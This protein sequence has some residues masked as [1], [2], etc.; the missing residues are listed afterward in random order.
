SI[1]IF[2]C[3]VLMELVRM[4]SY[5]NAQLTRLVVQQQQKKKERL[6]LIKTALSLCTPNWTRCYEKDFGMSRPMR[7]LNGPFVSWGG[8]G[9]DEQNNEAAAVRE[10][11]L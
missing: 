8:E 11:P 5:Q 9:E 1:P 10:D 3:N 2:P 6:I 7:M 4:V